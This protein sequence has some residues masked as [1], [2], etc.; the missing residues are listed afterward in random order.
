M[1]VAEEQQRR[2][3]NDLQV[4]E[5]RPVLDIVEIVAGTLLDRGV[6][7]Q[8]VHLRPAGD[9]GLLD[10]A[11]HVSGDALRK[12][13]HEMRPLWPRPNYAHL[14]EQPIEELGQLTQPVVAL[15]P[16]DAGDSWV[17]LRRPDRAAL[18]LGVG[19]HR[20]ELERIEWQTIQADALLGKK[21][22]TARAELDQHG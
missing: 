10:V 16:T 15:E 18:G 7:A 22:W 8:A 3:G 9:T 14:T 5:Q 13:L 21:D 1:A 11:T 12:L 2:F 20:A 6:A 4:E 19:H 17:V